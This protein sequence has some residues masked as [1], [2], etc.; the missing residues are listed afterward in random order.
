MRGGRFGHTLFARIFRVFMIVESFD[1]GI[2]RGRQR[3]VAPSEMPEE[4][5]PEAFEG[6][7]EL[8]MQF[9]APVYTLPELPMLEIPFWRG[10]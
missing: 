4:R 3:L 5:T 9:E 10:P 7:G 2:L 6:L 8:D 1:R